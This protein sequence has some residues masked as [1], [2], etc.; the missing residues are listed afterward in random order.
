MNQRRGWEDETSS[1]AVNAQPWDPPPGMVKRQCP[2]RGAA[3]SSPLLRTPQSRSART[4]SPSAADPRQRTRRSRGGLGNRFTGRSGFQP[5]MVRAHSRACAALAMPGNS[6][7][8]SQ[9]APLLEHGADR[10][11]LSLA[12]GE[13]AGAWH[14]QRDRQRQSLSRNDRIRASLDRS[15]SETCL[16]HPP[17][18]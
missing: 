5:A 8:S 1:R 17:M 15:L 10:S 14:Q 18:S 16:Y 6:R 9:L 7:R 4:A 13:H 2:C 11:S 12:D 3:T